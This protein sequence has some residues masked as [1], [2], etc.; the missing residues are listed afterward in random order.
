MGCRTHQGG[1]GRTGRNQVRLIIR[2]RIFRTALRL[3]DAGMS[4]F[5]AI[6]LLFQILF[7]SRNTLCLLKLQ[8]ASFHENKRLLQNCRLGILW[9]EKNV[10]LF[11]FFSNNKIL[12]NK[13]L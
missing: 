12:H 8:D 4:I 7:R 10:V 13:Q 3:S 5:R 1:S 6:S 11:F 2:A 9:K